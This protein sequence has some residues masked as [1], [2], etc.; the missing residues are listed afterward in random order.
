MAD[1]YP[2]SIERLIAIEFDACINDLLAA[3]RG[4]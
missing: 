2:R 1:V 4:G 3:K